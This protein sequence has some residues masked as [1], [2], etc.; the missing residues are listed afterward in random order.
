MN[1]LAFFGGPK[2]MTELFPSMST[3]GIEEKKAVQR[4]M[5]SGK[6]SEFRGNFSN[7]FYGGEEHDL[8]IPYQHAYLMAHFPREYREMA[9]CERIA[10]AKE[11]ERVS[12]FRDKGL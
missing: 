3:I 5:D 11:L 6:L 12:P 8:R 9:E 4:V 2:I 7:N 1:K 10:A